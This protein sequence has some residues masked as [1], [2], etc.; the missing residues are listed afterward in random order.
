M[1]TVDAGVWETSVGCWKVVAVREEDIIESQETGDVLFRSRA[2]VSAQ[3]KLRQDRSTA[4][5]EE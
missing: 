2:S 4:M 3:S 1:K 5:C